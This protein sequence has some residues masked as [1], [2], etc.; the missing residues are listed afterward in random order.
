MLDVFLRKPESQNQ[1]E[2]GIK[3]S[4][5]TDK[6]I[7]SV[8]KSIS[9]R[10]VGTLDTILISYIITGKVTAAVSIGSVEAITK[11]VLYYF[12]ERLWAHIH[13]IKINIFKNA[14]RKRF[15]FKVGRIELSPSR[16]DN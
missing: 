8:L 1:E 7:K 11:I 16:K 6:P 4:K 5:S 14:I 12:H 13:R 10:I 9:W 15:K 2:N 3:I